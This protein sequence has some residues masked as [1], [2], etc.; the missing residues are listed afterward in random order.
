MREAVVAAER[1]IEGR[2]TLGLGS[3]D[4]KQGYRN[5]LEAALMLGD[6]DT[7]DRLLRIVEDAP[8]GLRPPYLVALAQRYRARLAGDAPEADRLFAAAAAGFAAIDV[9]FDTAIVQL[10]H[11]EWLG[12]IGRTDEAENALE[13]A[14]ETFERLRATPWLERAVAAGAVHA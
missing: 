2:Q 1:A 14:R 12:R 7:V 5:G 10:E 13:P 3:Q 6:L 9:A 8:I 4:V 11:A